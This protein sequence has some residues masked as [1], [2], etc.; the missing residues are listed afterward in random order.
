MKIL[1]RSLVKWK[2]DGSEVH[3]GPSTRHKL[4][5]IG[6]AKIFT[7]EQMGYIGLE[8]LNGTWLELE[9]IN[10]VPFPNEARVAEGE[11]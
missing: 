9:R 6:S 2:E 5:N 8:R 3:A 7:H 10:L 11:H 1:T 4:G